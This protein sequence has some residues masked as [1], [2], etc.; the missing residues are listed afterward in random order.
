M[1]IQ[2]APIN[3]PSSSKGWNRYQVS[4]DGRRVVESATGNAWVSSAK[5]G[6]VE[7][8][9]TLILTVQTM[10]RVGK[11]RTARENVETEKYTLI[12]DSTAT[13]TP[14]SR[15]ATS[16]INGVMSTYMVGGYVTVT[17]A[18]LA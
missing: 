4:V 12:A 14:G 17:G 10:R 11:S 2:F 13:C 15:E 16:G 9:A 1:T 18:R 7:D 3:E 8:G 6:E 5:A